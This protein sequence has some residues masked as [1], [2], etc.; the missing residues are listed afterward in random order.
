VFRFADKEFL[1]RSARAKKFQTRSSPNGY[2]A[3]E[4][5]DVPEQIDAMVLVKKFLKANPSVC[6]VTGRLMTN[7]P[8]KPRGHEGGSRD[9]QH[10]HGSTSCIVAFLGEQN[11]CFLC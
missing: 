2:P 9:E 1:G 10:E 4:G 8:V 7:R 6:K 5:A 3:S 11:W